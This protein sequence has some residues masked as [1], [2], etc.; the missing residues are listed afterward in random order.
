[1]IAAAITGFLIALAFAAPPGPVL[2]ETIRRGIRTGFRPAFL[3][4][5]GSIAGDSV[6]CA[7]AIAG[8]APL[9]QSAWLRIPWTVLGAGILVY[10]G[11]RAI[12]DGIHASAEI[13]A[14][15]R[16]AQAGALQSGLIISLGNPMALGYWF[17][18]GGAMA[19]N[20]IMQTPS[21]GLY[22]AFA[23]GFVLAM[24]GWAVL[25]ALF[26]GWGRHVPGIWFFRT[27]HLACGC[28]LLFFAVQM[29]STLFLKLP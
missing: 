21:A 8:L 20:A 13:P 5:L 27:I 4:Q 15:A 2:M 1:M 16:F 18:V 26:A 25:M 24:L 29:A 11:L 28:F 9:M 12:W 23:L 6:W 19:S 7:A 3:V 14:A 17:A 10:L 22:G